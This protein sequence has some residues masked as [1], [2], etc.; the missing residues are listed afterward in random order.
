MF[1]IKYQNSRKDTKCNL[2]K[3]AKMRERLSFSEPFGDARYYYPQKNDLGHHD[4]Q[5]QA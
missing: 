4:S 5:I 1:I 2:A 3:K